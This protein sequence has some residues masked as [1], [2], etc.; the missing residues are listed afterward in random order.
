MKSSVTDNS[1]FSQSYYDFGKGGLRLGIDSGNLRSLNQ[2]R[3]RNVCFAIAVLVFRNSQDY[4]IADAK[5]SV[6]WQALQII[7]AFLICF[8]SKLAHLAISFCDR[9]SE[10]QDEH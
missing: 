3:P 4:D 6:L 1:I 5:D 9:Y 10:L 8:P 7:K 2:N